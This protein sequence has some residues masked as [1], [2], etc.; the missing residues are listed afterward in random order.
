M[1]ATTLLKNDHTKVKGLFREYQQT[2]E[3]ALKSKSRLFEKIKQELEVHSAIEEEIFYPAVR[4]ARTRQATELVS[5]AIEEHAT[6]KRLLRDI[7][8]LTPQD[9]DFETKMSELINDVKH[10]AKE[11]EEEMFPEAQKHLSAE[12]LEQLGERMEERKRSLAPS[13]RRG[14][15][16]AA[17]PRA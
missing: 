17:Q 12:E 8:D 1:K 3:R 5:E 10:H 13:K 16:P 7:S 11:E 4:E 9:E 2:G 14:R 15:A 6:V